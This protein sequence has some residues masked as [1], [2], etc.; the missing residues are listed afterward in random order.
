[1]NDIQV[2]REMLVQDAQVSLCQGKGN[3]SVDLAD[4]QAKTEVKIKGLP[5]DSVVVR[6]EKFNEPTK[7]FQ[8]TKGEQK[9]ADFVIVSNKDAKKW[10]VCIEIQAGN[11]KTAKEVT[12]QL[13]GSKCFMRYCKYIGKSFWEK[14]FLNNYTWRFVSIVDARHSAKQPTRKHKQ[15][16]DTPHKFQKLHGN[17]HHFKKL[18][19]ET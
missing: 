10:I 8:G 11:S 5:S 2:L 13:M 9:R 14:S 17:Q 4:G 19:H 16:Y 12:S 7:L 1:M 3:P 6:S 18:I 15:V